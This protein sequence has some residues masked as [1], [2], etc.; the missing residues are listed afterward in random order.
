MTPVPMLCN[1]PWLKSALRSVRVLDASWHMPATQRKGS[2]EFLLK[3]IP[4]WN[5]SVN[6]FTRDPV[7]LI[8]MTLLTTPH[9]SRTCSHQLQ[10]SRS[11]W[12]IWELQNQIMLFS[13]TLLDLDQ[14]VVRFGLSKLLDTS[15]FQ[16]WTADWFNGNHKEWI[17]N[18]VHL[19][20]FRYFYNRTDLIQISQSNIERVSNPIWSRI[21]NKFLR[22]SQASLV[23][24]WMQDLQID[25]WELILN[26]ALD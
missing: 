4:V 22:S 20:K 14:A 2:S 12:E 17:L 23:R 7:S 9:P 5:S 24:Y 1:V 15:A 8:L 21:T 16:C 3:R 19:N 11:R 26:L 6:N 18:Q 13:M 25:F 10:I